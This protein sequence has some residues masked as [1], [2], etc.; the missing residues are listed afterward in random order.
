LSELRRMAESAA[1]LV[2]EV[3]PQQQPGYYQAML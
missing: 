1:L 3:L 2:G